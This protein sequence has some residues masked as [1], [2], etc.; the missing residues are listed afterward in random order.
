MTYAPAMK[1]HNYYFKSYLKLISLILILTSCA[2]LNTSNKSYNL[3]GKLSYISKEQSSIFKVKIS[4]NV[5]KSST[6]DWSLTSTYIKK[7][8]FLDFE[9]NDLLR[10]IKARPLLILGDS[11]TTDHI[12]PAGV[13][14]EDSSCLLYTS[15][16]PRDS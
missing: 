10:D 9:K 7:P 6:Y 2:S 16:S 14:K 13:I 3:E 12:S 4:S 1:F 5:K 8:P 11:I 15:P